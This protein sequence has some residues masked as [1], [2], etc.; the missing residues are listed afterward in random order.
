M[1]I[2]VAGIYYEFKFRGYHKIENG[3]TAGVR[4]ATVAHVQ[5]S[6]KEDRHKH[7]QRQDWGSGGMRN[8]TETSR[9]GL[10]GSQYDGEGIRKTS[11]CG[12]LL[13]P[14]VIKGQTLTSRGYSV[15]GWTCRSIKEAATSSQR[16][17]QPSVRCYYNSKN[18]E[19]CKLHFTPSQVSCETLHSFLFLSVLII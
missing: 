5:C 11:S 7:T 2:C 15:G 8:R 1:K 16:Q 10:G 4:A 12:N 6:Q 18:C 9:A 14:L 13:L 3:G 19:L 17:V